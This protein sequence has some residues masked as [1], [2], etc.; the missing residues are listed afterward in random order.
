MDTSWDAA[1]LAVSH[2][3]TPGEPIVVADLVDLG[4]TVLEG[5]RHI[6]SGHD[7]RAD[8][9]QLLAAVHPEPLGRLERIPKRF[10]DRYLALIARRAAGEPLGRLVGHVT[11]GKIEVGV[12]HGVFVPRPSS[13]WTAEQVVD[14]VRP[15]ERPIVIDVCTGA[16][17]MAL[18]IAHAVPHAEVWG[19]DISPV[20]CQQAR[21]NAER[22]GLHNVRFRSGDAYGPLPRRLQHRVDAIV[23]YIPYLTNEDIAGLQAEI[24]TYEPLHTLT[25]LSDDGFGLVRRILREARVWLRPHGELLVQM[26]A[27][28]AP[29]LANMLADAGLTEIRQDGQHDGWDVVVRSRP[30]DPTATSRG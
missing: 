24:G 16:G 17:A 22:L 1:S 13:V 23:G 12:R 28:T 19:T 9:E 14:L 25:D 15:R 5:S 21:R 27:E 26:D 2:L 20:A 7:H 6:D 3:A 8:A 4:Q 29:R 30:S 18:S 11:F 10:R